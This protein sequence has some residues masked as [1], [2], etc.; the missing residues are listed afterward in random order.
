MTD[1]LNSERPPFDLS[2]YLVVGRD[3]IGGR[4]LTEVVTAAV[5][6]GVTLVQLREKTASDEE[7]AELARG[8]KVALPPSV[9]LI[10]NDRVEAALIAGADG[11]HL[12][13]DDGPPEAARERLGPRAI[14]GLSVGNLAEAAVSDVSGVDYLGVGPVFATGTKADAGAAIGPEGVLPVRRALERPSVAIGGIK[15]ATTADV[16]ASGADGVAVVSAIAAAANP[17][18]A[19]RDL[20]EAV[21]E[22][23]ARRAAQQETS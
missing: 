10:L 8:L 17:E 13:Q 7:V 23:R 5:R 16:M 12:G 21:R 6:G 9:P 1:S 3:D 18:A 15:A 11:V 19:A 14:L 22:G 20:V 2:L 4:D